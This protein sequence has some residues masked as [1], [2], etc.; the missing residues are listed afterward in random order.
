M[1]VFVVWETRFTNQHGD[2]VVLVRDAFVRRNR[3]KR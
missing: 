3:P 2:T 1:M